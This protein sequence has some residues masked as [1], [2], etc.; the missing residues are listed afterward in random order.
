MP[1]GIIF[2]FNNQPIDI[3]VE[4]APVLDFIDEHDGDNDGAE[5]NFNGGIGLRYYFK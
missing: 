2:D 3:Y 4:I 5:F 1:I